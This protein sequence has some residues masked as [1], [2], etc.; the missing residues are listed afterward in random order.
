MEAVVKTK[1]LDEVIQEEFFKKVFYDY[2]N[3]LA[4]NSA[5]K[6]MLT[7][8]LL[9]EAKFLRPKLIIALSKD[10]EVFCDSIINLAIAIELYH[11]STLIHDDLPCLD[12]DDFRRGQPSCHKVFGEGQALLFGDWLEC[13]SFYEIG[14]SKLPF[15]TLQ[16]LYKAFSDVLE[17]QLIELAYNKFSIDEKVDRLKTASLFHGALLTVAHI[18]NKSTNDSFLISRLGETLGM[19]F[20]ARDNK[21]DLLS[22]T[23]NLTVKEKKE[24]AEI[25]QK[26]YVKTRE[27]LLSCM[28]AF[29]TSLGAVPSS[30]IQIINELLN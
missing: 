8:L 13:R 19:F 16:P 7:H 27:E 6:P 18:A 12:N 26:N 25:V 2:V 17:G 21:D 4:E 29:Q 28:H 22:D 23:L 3:K 15:E 5:Y 20:Q 14:Q 9:G 30:L 24:V 1:M 11:S 10:L